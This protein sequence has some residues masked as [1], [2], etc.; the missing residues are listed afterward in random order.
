[1]GGAYIVHTPD[2]GVRPLRAPRVKWHST[3]PSWPFSFS[4]LRC[5][6]TSLYSNGREEF[7]PQGDIEENFHLSFLLARSFL[8][9]QKVPTGLGGGGLDTLLC[10]RGT[11]AGNWHV[12]LSAK[13]TL[14]GQFSCRAEHLDGRF[15]SQMVLILSHL[16]TRLFQKG[17]VLR[18]WGNDSAG[19][20][21]RSWG[22]FS[23]TG[24]Q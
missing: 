6:A 5:Y 19:S 7:E 2:Y 16:P 17:C 23:S 9:P 14:F 1:M 3:W 15:C 24:L 22:P 4:C 10:A 11:S 8:G 12:W 13:R 20:E 18:G 21:L